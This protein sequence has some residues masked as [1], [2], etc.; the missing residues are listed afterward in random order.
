VKE[1]LTARGEFPYQIS[2]VF[3]LPAPFL[4]IGKPRTEEPENQRTP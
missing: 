1:F 4:G 2:S 3:I